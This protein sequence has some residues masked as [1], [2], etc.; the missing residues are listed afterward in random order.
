M[1]DVKHAGHPA[2]SLSLPHLKAKLP[3]CFSCHFFS[4]ALY[5]NDIKFGGE[6]EMAYLMALTEEAHR[7]PFF[8]TA[9][10]VLYNLIACTLL[11][12]KASLIQPLRAQ[13][14]L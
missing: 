14:T 6:S 11:H 10:S 8:S 7:P 13:G 3:V 2:W 5:R 1:N 4:L 12:R 9:R